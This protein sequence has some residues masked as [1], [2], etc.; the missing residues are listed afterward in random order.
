MAATVPERQSSCNGT[1][2]IKQSHGE[3]AADKVVPVRLP[4]G[5]KKSTGGMSKV[6]KTTSQGLIA[7][8]YDRSE[9]SHVL[10]AATLGGDRM[11][12]RPKAVKVYF[13]N[14]A[15]PS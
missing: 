6:G 11:L 1:S 7:R 15:K 8:L 4:H 3:M 2:W 5:D 14:R 13:E 10:R 12:R 9:N